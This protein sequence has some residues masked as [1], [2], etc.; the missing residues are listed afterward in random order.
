V[1]PQNIGVAIAV[2]VTGSDD[3]KIYVTVS[4][5]LVHSDCARDTGQPDGILSR[6][7]VTP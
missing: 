4:N 1:A 7:S 5:H 3:V 6:R 2:E